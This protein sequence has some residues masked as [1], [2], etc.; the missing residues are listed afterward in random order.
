MQDCENAEQFRS[1]EIGDFD[2]DG[3]MEFQDA[4]GHPIRFI[5]WP[6]GFIPANGAESAFQS[7]D[8]KKDKD[9][10]DTLGIFTNAD[11]NIG[12]RLVPLIYSAGPD[13]IYDINIGK[14]PGGDYAYKLESGVID[15]YDFDDNYTAQWPSGAKIGTPQD[16]VDGFTGASANGVLEY[17]D[18]INNHQLGL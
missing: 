5:R 16:G 6:A 2:G 1:D 9:P 8:S 10:F 12:Y 14:V 4:W 13:G 18:N 11:P 3:L 7:G 15:P 17:K